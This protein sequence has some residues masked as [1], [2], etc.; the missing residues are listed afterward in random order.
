[1][2]AAPNGA[3][4]ESMRH[5]A[6]MVSCST[7]ASAQCV[8][9]KG[10]K[11]VSSVSLPS[12]RTA[13]TRPT[14]REAHP[15]VC[16]ARRTAEPLRRRAEISGRTGLRVNAT[17][18]GPDET[19]PEHQKPF[20][21]VALKQARE[22]GWTFT[23][24]GHWFGVVSCPAGEHTFN[25]DKTARG[26]ETKAKEVPKQL[27][28]CQHGTPATLGSKV[29]ARRA[30]CERLLL[31]AEDLIS[32]AA[33]DLWRA[34]QRQ[35]AFTEFDRLRIVLDTADA[36][37]DEVLAAEQEQALER[38]AD[39]ED[40]PGAAD[41]ART[42]GDADVAAGEARDVAAKIRRQGIAVPLRTRAQAARS[43][44]SEL[45]ERLERL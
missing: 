7:A 43:R 22:A 33:R 11:N 40:A 8:R 45:R 31:R 35:A 5:V 34:E 28:S 42:L 18:Y 17:V 36:T 25:V 2:P 23:T 37:A 30:E 15:G 27:R 39:L 20:W 13:Q 38:A 21:N 24:G 14:Q 32:A 3:V 16:S 26:G 41:I 9:L 44:V 6:A 10:P 19:W 1:L 12:R 29:A 4:R